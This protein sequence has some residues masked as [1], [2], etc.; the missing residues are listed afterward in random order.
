M[1]A[2]SPLP[3]ML[4]RIDPRVEEARR[5]PEWARFH[6]LCGEAG[7]Y[8]D[9]I[10]R[11]G[12][13]YRASA[14]TLNRRG[15]GRYSPVLLGQGEAR[16]PVSA[17]EAAYRASGRAVGGA[18]EMLARRLGGTGVATRATSGREPDDDDDFE[19]L[20]DDNDFEGLL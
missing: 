13:T 7:L 8:F 19:D 14:F 1:S 9:H 16:D 15:P 12:R 4:W 17:I 5:L 3:E 2:W 11:A 18:G 20:L 10:E 6:R